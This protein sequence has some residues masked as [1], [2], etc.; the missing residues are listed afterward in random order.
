[1]F[2]SA[3]T[4]DGCLTCNTDAAMCDVCEPGFVRIS[5]TECRGNSQSHSHTH[6]PPHTHTPH[7]HIHTHTHKFN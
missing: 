1:M 7:T 2:V 5:A 6:P 3:C 4:V